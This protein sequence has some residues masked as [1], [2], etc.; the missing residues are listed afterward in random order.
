MSKPPCLRLTRVAAWLAEAE[1]DVS[2]VRVLARCQAWLLRLPMKAL[3][4]RSD[5]LSERDP[6]W[7][8]A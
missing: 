2:V 7:K 6:V 8:I 4:T 3:V 1:A 5:P